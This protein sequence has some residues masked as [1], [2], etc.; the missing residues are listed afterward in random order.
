MAVSSMSSRHSM[1]K[2]LLHVRGGGG[3]AGKARR[4]KGGGGRMQ[5]EELAVIDNLCSP[6]KFVF[7]VFCKIGIQH[8]QAFWDIINKQNSYT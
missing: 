7:A 1:G 3:S 8:S 4:R 2:H 5:T 6:G